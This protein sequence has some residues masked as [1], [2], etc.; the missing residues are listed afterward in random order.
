[1]LKKNATML[2]KLMLFMLLATLLSSNVFAAMTDKQIE[3]KRQLQEKILKMRK[4]QIEAKIQTQKA[5]DE[6]ERQDRATRKAAIKSYA[7]YIKRVGNKKNEKAADALFQL[8]QLWYSDSKD[9]FM[10][11]YEKYEADYLKFEK[12]KITKEPKE[13]EKNYDQSIKYFTRLVKEY[14]NYANRDMALYRL[15]VMQEELLKPEQ[16]LVHFMELSAKYPTSKFAETA[17]LRV[18]GF[19]YDKNK[20]D[21][22]LVYF[23]KV[24]LNGAGVENWGIAQYRI[25]KSY[26]RKYDLDKARKQFFE[27]LVYCDQG[28]FNKKNFRSES[29]EELAQ[30]Y[31][32]LKNGA[33]LCEEDIKVYHPGMAKD[34]EYLFFRIGEKAQEYDELANAVFAYNKLLA[35]YPSSSYAPQAMNAVIDVLTMEKKFKEA[36]ETRIKLVDTFNKNSVWAQQNS[37]DPKRI[38]KA[39]RYVESALSLIPLYYHTEGDKTKNKLNY[40]TAIK[41]YEMYID[42]FGVNDPLKTYEYR[43]YLASCYQEVGEFKKAAGTFDA[44]VDMDTSKFPMDRLK[45]LKFTKETA[46]Y[47]SV[48]AYDGLMNE[49]IKDFKNEFDSIEVKDYINSCSRYIQKFPT[50]NKQA[51]EEIK[52]N[53][54]NLYYRGERWAKVIEIYGDFVENNKGS[55]YYRDVFKTLGQAY[56]YGKQY[57]IGEEKL[58]EYLNTYGT[59]VSVEEKDEVLLLLGVA[60]FG[61]GEEAQDSGKVDEAAHHFMRIH[62]VAPKS[63]VADIG[64]WNAAELYEKEKMY[65]KAANVFIYM[66][67]KYPKSKSAIPALLRAGQNFEKDSLPD[68]AAV[69]YISIGEK[70]PDTLDGL[71]GIYTAA[72]MYDSLSLYGKAGKTYELAESSKN[73]VNKDRDEGLYFAGLMY[74]KAKMW[75]DAIR[76]Y[77]KVETKY[78]ESKYLTDALYSVALTYKL[79]EKWPEAAKYFSNFAV[80]FETSSPKKSVVAYMDA[81]DCELK[82]EKIDFDR[83]EGML[84]KAMDVY[85]KNAEKYAIDSYY[86]AKAIFLM[87]EVTR[88]RMNAAPLGGYSV[89]IKDGET[90]MEQLDKKLDEAKTALLQ[91]ATKYYASVGQYQTE[92]WTLKANNAIGYMMME[93]AETIDTQKLQVKAKKKD[94]KKSL[95]IAIKIQVFKMNKQKMLLSAAERFQVNVDYALNNKVKMPVIDTAMIQYP[96]CG[97]LA[98]MTYVEMG[99]LFMESPIP[100]ELA[101]TED[102]QYFIEEL[103]A[104]KYEMQERALPLLES[105]L[106]VSYDKTI[107]NSWTDKVKEEIR[108]IDASNVN[109]VAKARTDVVFADGKIREIEKSYERAVAQLNTLTAIQEE[110]LVNGMEVVELLALLKQMQLEAQRQT[111]DEKAALKVVQDDLVKVKA[112]VDQLVKDIFVLGGGDLSVFEKSKDGEGSSEEDAEAQEETE[113]TEEVKE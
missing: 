14:P 9:G 37:V 111:E 28:Y 22:A 10:S 90:V 71:R 87:G 113:E 11:A 19:Y 15:G 83:I 101:G 53:L 67:E 49:K 35:K 58:T 55:Q 103:E 80:Q 43:F 40:T 79:Q 18:G 39:E 92:E 24:T 13:P 7:Q 1:M 36:N 81:A 65:S 45:K 61:Q 12:K 73:I 57:K 77:R 75:E 91:E 110:K 50:E 95:E 20:M 96:K 25:A 97:Y 29:I 31:G 69:A 6:L 56:Y 16:G 52:V 47:M 51:I 98:A 76:V 74:E 89:E 60:I 5:L 78:P 66:Q 72:K 64:I 68:S 2:P 108:K 109:L 105:V 63:K 38:I 21:S 4:E 46:A 106:K 86:A 27:Y 48:L 34:E 3:K 70:Y 42:W 112:E 41:Y 82:L 104:K 44:I 94:D 17:Y 84:E 88:A 54:G 59:Q 62:K 85:E 26:F 102:E 100:A 30:I 23:T 32:E 99:Q 33:Q 93:Y 8:G 107:D